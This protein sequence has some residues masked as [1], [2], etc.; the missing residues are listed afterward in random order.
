M[1]ILLKPLLILISVI[2][3]AGIL[4][5]SSTKSNDKKDD[6]KTII[7]GI[8]DTFVPMGF[9][10]DKGDIVG[11]DIDLAKKVFENLDYNYKFQTINWDMK[12]S[13]LNS[14]SID[15]IWNGYTKTPEREAKV[16]LTKPYLNNTQAI[17]ILNTADINSKNDLKNKIVSTQNGSSSLDAIEKDSTL[18]NNMKD[19]K[20]VLFDTYNEAFMDLE[21]RRVDAIV[22]DEVLV[23]YYISQRDSNKYKVLDEVLADEEYC[24]AVRKT[25]KNLLDAINNELDTMKSNGE[26]NEIKNKWF[27]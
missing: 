9:K 2:L 25:D 1:K 21:A 16:A 7:I 19:G 12:E 10:D 11:F 4:I 22:V 20:P 15:V 18:L 14:G 5:F 27:K 17:V 23:R 6:T 3:I 26:F 13:E 24:V 8:D